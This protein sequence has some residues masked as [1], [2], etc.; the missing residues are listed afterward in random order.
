MSDA[1]RIPTP[2]ELQVTRKPRSLQPNAD[3]VRVVRGYILEEGQDWREALQ[4]EF[5][6]NV[7]SRLNPGDRIEVHNYTHT[8]QFF[9]I[10]FAANDKGIQRLDCGFTAI[11]PPDLELPDPIMREERY[12]ARWDGSRWGVL[13]IETGEIIAEFAHKHQCHE[14]IAALETRDLRAD[15]E[16]EM[17]A[18]PVNRPGQNSAPRPSTG[19]RVAAHPSEAQEPKDWAAEI[20]AA[21]AEQQRSR[22]R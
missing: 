10:V 13:V 16:R 7:L 18:A 15:T 4:P 22:R 12:R 3:F 11:W 20:A 8:V 9:V 19:T 1:V 21:E 2:P 5:W 17:A 14:A 6:S